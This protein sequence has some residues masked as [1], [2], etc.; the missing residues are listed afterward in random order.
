MND[1]MLM[2]DIGCGTAVSSPCYDL[3]RAKNQGSNYIL[4]RKTFPTHFAGRNTRIRYV[5]DFHVRIARLYL[6]H[7]RGLLWVRVGE[8]DF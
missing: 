1:V 8:R 3:S 7:F 5:G 4:H 2:V 6:L